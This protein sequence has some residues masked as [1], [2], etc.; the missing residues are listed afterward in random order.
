ADFSN[1][2][3]DL[4]VTAQYTENGLVVT[5]LGDV[6]LDGEVTATDALLAMR[7]AMS[8]TVISGQGFVNGDMDGDGQLTSSDAILIMRAVMGL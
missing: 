6:D 5:L 7:H 8:I 3:S 2:T 1:V 4:V